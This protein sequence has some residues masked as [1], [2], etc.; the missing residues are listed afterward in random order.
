[1]NIS[2][3]TNGIDSAGRT[4]N[5]SERDNKVTPL[6]NGK[7]S[8][9]TN[10]VQL[11]ASSKSIQQVEAEVRAMSDV[12]DATVDRIRA[13]IDSGNYKIDYERL[14]GKMLDFEERLN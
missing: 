10:D 13:A 5:D 12:D 4:R 6:S 2:K 11:S 8:A 14:A 7:E 3:I 9:K 1:M